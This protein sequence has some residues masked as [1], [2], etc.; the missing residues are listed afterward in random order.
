[1]SAAEHLDE[2]L[3]ET[4]A[5]G[6]DA[7]SPYAIGDKGHE[8]QEAEWACRKLAKLT[9]DRDAILRAGHAQIESVKA[10][11]AGETTRLARDI[12]YFTNLLI[13]WHQERLSEAYEE[14]GG[15]WSKVRGKT[16][17]L[18]SGV[19]SA[20]QSPPSVD[21]DDEVFLP[22]APGELV[23]VKREPDKTAILAHV[24]TT[25]E[26]PAGV[27]FREGDV[28]FKVTVG[29]EAKRMVDE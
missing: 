1:M 24:K 22:A 4:W 21:V 17:R 12:D 3:R 2:Y 20:R 18:P 27:T 10:W 5:E 8:L 25:G 11:M 6:A 15:D 7:E 26:V 13:A 19:V 28:T 14:A 16:R 23:R 29:S 9:G